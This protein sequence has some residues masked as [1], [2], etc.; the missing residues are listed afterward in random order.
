MEI[1]NLIQTTEI[2]LLKCYYYIQEKVTNDLI[3]LE[4][5]QANCGN[6]VELDTLH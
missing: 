6:L 4:I 2:L 5:M 3:I 1:L